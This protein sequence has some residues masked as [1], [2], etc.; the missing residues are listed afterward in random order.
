MSKLIHKIE[1]ITRVMVRANSV[2]PPC[3][4]CPSRM[5]SLDF[6]IFKCGCV[7]MA[8]L[9]FQTARPGETAATDRDRVDPDQPPPAASAK[10]LRLSQA[11][12]Q[13]V[14]EFAHLAMEIPRPVFIWL[15][16]LTAILTIASRVPRHANPCPCS[17][18]PCR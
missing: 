3:D 2:T 6:I 1:M 7:V 5:M 9:N 11:Q 8:G 17:V 4:L 12:P 18:P 15:M 16:C 13:S 10:E 14:T